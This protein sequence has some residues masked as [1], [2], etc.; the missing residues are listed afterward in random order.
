MDNPAY[1]D[2]TNSVHPVTMTTICH[3]SLQE[4]GRG[5][6]NQ[7]VDPGSPDLCTP[8]STA[9][10]ESTNAGF[11]TPKIIISSATVAYANAPQ[12][13]VPRD[14]LCRYDA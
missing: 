8:R 9:Y 1:W 12:K 7:A 6:Y 2:V 4:F 10:G 14:S 5:A 3:C 11:R 13:G